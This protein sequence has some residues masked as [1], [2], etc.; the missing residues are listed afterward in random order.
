MAAKGKLQG[1]HD[2]I[3]SRQSDRY[4]SGKLSDLRGRNSRRFRDR[5]SLQE[6]GMHESGTPGSGDAPSKYI[7]RRM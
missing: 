2:D 3:F 7:A 5:P 4:L 6:Q 1:L